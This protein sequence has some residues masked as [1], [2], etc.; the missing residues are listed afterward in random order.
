MLPYAV[1]SAMLR[2]VPTEKESEKVEILK[3]SNVAKLWLLG[4]TVIVV[5]KSLLL[6]ALIQ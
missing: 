2:P 1:A 3:G 5:G 6:S 4:T